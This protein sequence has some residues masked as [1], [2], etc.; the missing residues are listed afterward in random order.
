MPLFVAPQTNTF[1]TKWQQYVIGTLDG[2][3][4]IM[5]YAETFGERVLGIFC[6]VGH[7]LGGQEGLMLFR[8][9]WKDNLLLAVSVLTYPTDYML[10]CSNEPSYQTRA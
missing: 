2:V 6:V 4:N 8:F 7:A 9:C 3:G 10:V 1:L 5:S